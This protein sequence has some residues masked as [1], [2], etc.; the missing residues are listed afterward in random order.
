M[1]A[2]ALECLSEEGTLLSYILLNHRTENSADTQKLFR[3]F[4]TLSTW[5]RVRCE[6]GALV[7]LLWFCVWCLCNAVHECVYLHRGRPISNPRRCLRWISCK[8]K[9]LT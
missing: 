5:G 2:A 8:L 7:L 9:C 4:A 1:P 6:E 3:W